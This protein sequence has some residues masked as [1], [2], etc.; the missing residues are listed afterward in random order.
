MVPLW[1]CCASAVTVKRTTR[2]ALLM[3]L[4]MLIAEAMNEFLMMFMFVLS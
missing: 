1:I 4:E 3:M 2:V